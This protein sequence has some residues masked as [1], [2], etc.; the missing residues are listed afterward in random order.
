MSQLIEKYNELK[1]ELEKIRE[2]HKGEDEGWEDIREDN[3]L[4]QMDDVW[5]AMS[6]A[7]WQEVDPEY[8]VTMRVI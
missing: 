5:W 2:E 7:E 4:D 8:P 1:T 6:D 3:I